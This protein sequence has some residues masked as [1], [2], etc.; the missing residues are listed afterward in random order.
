[1]PSAVALLDLAI[2]AVPALGLGIWQLIA[3]NRTIARDRAARAEPPS[4]GAAG[5]AIG[6]HR[7]D[8]G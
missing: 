1:M 8:D 2:V 3:I 6:E 5:H 4:P 7:L